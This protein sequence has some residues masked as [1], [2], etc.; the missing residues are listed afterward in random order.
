MTS[1][2]AERVL[3][4]LDGVR[5]RGLAL[6]GPAGA[7]LVRD[8]ELRV[9]AAFGFTVL[10]AL[11]TTALAPLWMMAL[12]PVVLGVP[13]VVADVRY[14]VLRPRLY[15]RRL[16]CLCAGVPLVVAALNAGVLAGLVACA[17]VLIV[18]RTTPA[19]RLAGLAAVAVLCGAAALAGPLADLAFAHLHNFAALALFWLWRPRARRLHLVPLALFALVAAAVLFGALDPVWTRQALSGP[20]GLS[21]ADKLAALAPGL[22]APLGARLVLLFAFAQSL[23]YAVWLRLVP[24]EDRGRPTPRS[25]VRTVRA[26]TADFG[27]PGLC[28]C[29]VLALGITG[30]AAFD[31]FSAY[32]G[33]LRAAVFHGH[34]EL[35]ALALLFA[36]GR[37][38]LR[39]PS[40]T[41][42]TT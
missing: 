12:G 3:W 28:L 20:D 24:E 40:I 34:L 7:R 33:Y 36:E 21:G 14:L 23:H 38:S 18:S 29:L 41:T 19:R 1:L 26:L 42:E 15:R 13:H 25:F 5:R 27:A 9:A 17:A 11:A 31:L 30:W 8:R 39:P 10:V 6:L 4:P 16:L 37:A 32:D 22:P 35:A 2:T